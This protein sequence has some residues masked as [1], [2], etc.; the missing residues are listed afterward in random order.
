MPAPTL[1]I[2]DVIGSRT[3]NL[4]SGQTTDDARLAL[5]GTADAHAT[6]HIYDGDTLLKTVVADANGEWVSRTPWLTNGQRYDFQARDTDDAQR[7]QAYA[8]TIDAPWAVSPDTVVGAGNQTAGGS[9]PNGATA[10]IL[11]DGSVF[12][13]G[14]LKAAPTELTDV[15]QVY[16]SRDAFAGLKADGSV[17]VWGDFFSSNASPTV[18][19]GELTDVARVFTSAQAMAA[20]HTDGTVT[21][22][23][24]SDLG[25]DAAAVQDDLVNVMQVFYNAFAFAALRKD[26]TVVT[27]GSPTHGGD[28]QTVQNELVDVMQI[29]STTNGAFAALTRDGNVVT[30]GFGGGSDSLAVA[31]E[32][33]NVVQIVAAQGG[34]AALLEDGRVVNWG[35]WSDNV[36]GLENVVQLYANHY[37]YA[38]LRADGTIHAWGFTNGGGSTQGMTIDAV[39]QVVATREAFAAIREDGS[40]VVWGNDGD[41]GLI[42]PAIQASL[43]SG[44]VKVVATSSAFA[45]LKDDGSV[46]TWGNA[47]YGGNSDAVSTE[48]THVVHLTSNLG[49]FTALRENG[50]VVSWGETVNNVGVL[51]DALA[52]GGVGAPLS[53]PPAI[54]LL[55]DTGASASDGITNEGTL[56]VTLPAGAIA[57]EYRI[58]TD[59]DWTTGAGTSL[60]LADDTYAARAIQVRYINAE[61]S[62]SIASS[63][64]AQIKVDKSVPDA[65]E[66]QLAFDLGHDDEDGVSND[67]TMSVQGVSSGHTWGFSIDAGTRW[68]TGTG[69]SSFIL[70]AGEYAP[71]QVQVR[72]INV[73]GTPSEPASNVGVIVIDTTPPAAPSLSYARDGDG[74]TVTL[75]RLEADAIWAWKLVGDAEWTSGVGNTIALPDATYAAGAL[76]VRQTDLAG[77]PGNVATNTAPIAPSVPAPGPGPQPEPE[78][79]PE[80]PANPLDIDNDAMPDALEEHYGMI[81][82]ERDHDVAGSDLLFV[83]Q[84]YRDLLGREADTDGL[85]YWLGRLDH[86]L[87]RATFTQA[88]IDA[89]PGA[90][91][92]VLAYAGILQRAPESDGLH[93]WLQ[94]AEAGQATADLVQA[95]AVSTESVSA[96][97]DDAA[98]VQWLYSDVL[99]RPADAG[100]YA[101]WIEQLA[102]D[103]ARAQVLVEVLHSAEFASSLPEDY[104]HAMLAQTALLGHAQTTDALEA[105]FTW[106]AVEGED[107]LALILAIQ[108]SANYHGRFIDVP[109]DS[110]L[111]N[112]PWSDDAIA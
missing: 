21:A 20:L 50:S 99:G 4:Q 97:L 29:V 87:E 9:Q 110:A 96:G 83:M 13:H 92:L 16:S 106:M 19:P 107:V 65:L 33:Q 103:G 105:M 8:I 25:G 15:V 102:S 7:S 38:A 14:P 66:L 60:D 34:F 56:G 73:A 64:P 68:D 55:E 81:V 74:W 112:V 23:G 54:A 6:V 98:W 62:P 93:Y 75:G 40:V 77:N 31:Q 32:L 88:F 100:G 59:S 67:G 11:A 28:S 76:Q 45:A 69:T 111:P 109:Q 80:P 41:G 43:S 35:D 57:W 5:Y 48:L 70:P 37:A 86:D 36:S 2:R 24:A 78:P 39:V 30:W 91:T 90:D 95:I 108:G 85:G 42:P 104:A 84:T 79:E 47:D 82:G 27:W 51:K 17:Q 52:L 94:Q 46:V 89:V 53:G 10:V 72:Q 18:T 1:F 44:V 12:V 71:G 49:G 61:G 58:G 63:N 101:Y 26:G 22:W 3:G